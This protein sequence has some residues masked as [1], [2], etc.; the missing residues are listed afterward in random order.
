MFKKI[1][2]IYQIIFDYLFL[3]KTKLIQIFYILIGPLMALFIQSLVLA[4]YYEHISIGLFICCLITWGFSIYYFY[5]SS[6]V[7]PGTLNTNNSEEEY[8]L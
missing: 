8:S 3:R 7:D 4:K 2:K 5:K 6:V 1:R